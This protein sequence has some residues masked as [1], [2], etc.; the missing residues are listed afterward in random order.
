MGTKT[1]DT[2]TRDSLFLF[3][4]SLPISYSLELWSWV[5]GVFWEH[6]CCACWDAPNIPK[7]GY[8]LCVKKDHSLSL[9]LSLSLSISCSFT[10]T[11]HTTNA[12]TRTL[13]LLVLG[14][15]G[16]FLASPRC[17]AISH[18]YVR[19]SAERKLSSHTKTNSKTPRISEDCGNV[20]NQA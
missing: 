17:P 9:S 14:S 3:F 2:R 12:P 1:K 6:F 4:I 8:S 13:V 20:P 11:Q 18:P 5:L 16:Y 10:S 7:K 19:K 15:L